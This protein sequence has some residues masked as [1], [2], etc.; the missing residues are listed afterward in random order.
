ML[1]TNLK[2]IESREAFTRI[3]SETENLLI[4]CG[5]MD[6]LCIPVYRIAE[7]L[8]PHYSE[9]QFYDLESDNPESAVLFSFPG[10]TDLAAIPL[11][12][13]FKNGNLVKWTSGLQ[14]KAQVKAFLDQEFEELF[15]IK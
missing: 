2:H 6:S 11:T 12:L 9:V 8:E 13:Y 4:V 1:Y 5:R 10:I 3:L 7:E 15:T 14:T